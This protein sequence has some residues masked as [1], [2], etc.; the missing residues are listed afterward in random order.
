M[1][2]LKGQRM[3]SS[4]LIIHGQFEDKE[5]ETKSTLVATLL[6]QLHLICSTL[7]RQLKKE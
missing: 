4:V 7:S 1:L 6:D 3:W 5:I 2:L